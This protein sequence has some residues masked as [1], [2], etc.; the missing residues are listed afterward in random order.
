MLAYFV[1]NVLISLLVTILGA[2]ISAWLTGAK[3]STRKYGIVILAI[4]VVTFLASWFV[5]KSEDSIPLV[6]AGRVVNDLNQSVGQ[7]TITV[8]TETTTSDDNGNF[9]VDLRGKL[10]PY[11]TP[12]VHVSKPGY[13]SYDGTTHVPADD[14]VIKLHRP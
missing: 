3:W 6:V 10:K 7:A 2:I 12:R 9:S 4:F 1:Q 11:D 13:S 5:R 8:S 14:F